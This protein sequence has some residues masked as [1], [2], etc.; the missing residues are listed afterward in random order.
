MT[1]ISNPES[2]RI[3]EPP[4]SPADNSGLANPPVAPVETAL[5]VAVDPCTKPATPPPATSIIVHL[6]NG[7]KSEN[8]RGHNHCAGNNRKRCGNSVHQ[9]VE[10]GDEISQYLQNRSQCERYQRGRGAYPDE[11]FAKTCK[12]GF[13]GQSHN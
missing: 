4:S 8:E 11:S 1:G 12:P 2:A 7:S 6:N 13:R 9:V 10:P 3:T 5:A